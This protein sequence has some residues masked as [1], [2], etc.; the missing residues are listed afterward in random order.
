VTSEP[1]RGVLLLGMHRSGTSVATRILN[2]M[3]L[4]VAGEDDLI[5]ADE[6]NSRGYWESLALTE[7]DDR[8]L[9]ALGAP[10]FAPPAAE[11]VRSRLSDLGDLLPE[12]RRRAG[13][14]LGPGPW[15]WKDPR[16]CVLLP[17]WEQVLGDADPL[18][19]VHRDPLE[20]AQSV[21][22]RDG[23]DLPHC[24]ALWERSV[25]GVLQ[26][27][28]TRPLHV[29]SFDAL[30]EDPA[31]WAARVAT[32][33]SHHGFDV[34]PP[35]AETLQGEL[36]SPRS[37]R[38]DKGANRL[39]LSP[40]Q[41][42]LWE[43][44]KE[45]EQ[46]SGTVE[47]GLIP[48]Q[49]AST[50]SLLAARREAWSLATQLELQIAQRAHYETSTQ[51]RLL[52]LER[53]V[54]RAGEAAQREVQAARVEVEQQVRIVAGRERSA[55]E[56]SE[57][58]LAREREADRLRQDL[59]RVAE[60]LG[61]S[62]ELLAREE[63]SVLR[64]V[65]RRGYRRARQVARR[66]SPDA[67]QRLRA[68]LSP[69]A[70]RVAPRSAQSNA[71]AAARQRAAVAPP[72][73]E[74][75]Q[76]LHA[77]L[78]P[79][80]QPGS[81]DVVVL[82]VIDWH[83]R[84][85]RPQHLAL[86]LAEGGARVVYLSTEFDRL[87]PGRPPYRLLEQVADRVWVARLACPDPLPRI[88]RDPLAPYQITVVAEALRALTEDLGLG[89]TALLAQHPF[90]EPVLWA[91]GDQLLAYDLIDDH[92]GFEGTEPW[93]LDAERR[94]LAGVDVTTVTAAS[95]QEKAPGSVLVRNGADVER[96]ATPPYDVRRRARPTLGYFG[97]IAHWFDVELVALCARAHP[98][99]GVV[100][101]GSTT[102]AD[103]GGLTKLPNI[104]LLGELPYDELPSHLHGFDVC[105][106]PFHII[107]L[108]EHTNPVK[109]YEYLSAGKP[110]VATAMPEVRLMEPYVHIADDREKFLALLDKAMAEVGDEELAAERR[111]WARGH[112]WAA[113]AEAVAEAFRDR[114]PSASVIVLCYNNLELTRACLDSLERS[115][116]YLDCEIV[117]VDNASSD[118]TAE[119]L[120]AWAEDREDVVLV[121]NDENLG[122]SG[123]N[124][125]GL[126]AARGEVLVL[127]NNDTYVTD[128]WLYGLI[129][130]LRDDPELGL[131]GPVTNN[132][133]NEAKVDLKYRSMEE[134]A[135]AAWRYTSARFRQLLRVPTVA[136]FCV[137]MRREVYEEIGGLDEAFGVGFFEDDDYCRRIHAAGYEIAIAEDVF[138]HHHLSASF[139]ALG[140]A[141]KQELFEKNK[142]V[143]EAKWGEW[144]PHVYRTGERT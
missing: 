144:T 131:V 130:H 82:P 108:T 1:G 77:E 136:F 97:A 59:Q 80:G 124:N 61:R 27:A 119:W 14:V 99:W 22:R 75:E 95:L 53:D 40:E 104:H 45:L 12:A 5:P 113:R 140:A 89:F 50:P 49:T 20:V 31:G 111:A 81:I 35:D 26:A 134:M 58:L 28:A 54:Q 103:V 8:L 70:D 21:A 37:A 125:V 63:T 90:W 44:L 106:I 102:G 13:D 16:T 67:Q 127:L 96:F 10:W 30:Q 56:M 72:R 114:T 100:L 23:L 101:I 33:L 112:T 83:F 68:V 47:P 78:L 64:P 38:L 116:R 137:A 123:G 122:F 24:L 57:R 109:V 76:A 126:A 46:R 9:A 25:R 65:L 79:P 93:V 3:G 87:R 69:V 92:A 55:A 71:Y 2:L 42:A 6:E 51:E 105:M 117:V 15:V 52:A 135:D 18:V 115:T 120:R 62:T 73:F 88:Y 143:Y 29:E 141:R 138:V 36:V 98:D 17:F 110:V 11:E 107:P 66:L 94:M 85:Q 91:C 132:I 142:A 60:Q 121:L 86:E 128:G 41:S 43:L 84:I 34:R 39:A 4:H 129:R 7:L 48:G 74:R 32:F 133:G 19:M 139:D 118:G